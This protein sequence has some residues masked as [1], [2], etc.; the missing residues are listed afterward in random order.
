M[1]DYSTLQQDKINRYVSQNLAVLSQNQQMKSGS[2]AELI[3]VVCVSKQRGL[4][5]H[6]LL[7]VG[8]NP[9]YV[10]EGAMD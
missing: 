1:L 7:S 3:F 10:E 4:T 6:M 8:E 9:L 2:L 5:A